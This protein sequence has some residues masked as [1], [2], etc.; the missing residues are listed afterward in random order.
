MFK[1][2]GNRWPLL[3]FLVLSTLAVANSALDSFYHQLFLEYT[4]L[5]PAELDYLGD[6]TVFGVGE[7]RDSLRPWVPEQVAAFRQMLAEKLA[8]MD[9]APVPQDPGEKAVFQGI[10]WFLQT[11]ISWVDFAPYQ[12]IFAPITGDPFALR[13]LFLT[14]HLL[15]TPQDL[16]W[17]LQRLEQVPAKVEGWI[18]RFNASRE[19]GI[20][21]AKDPNRS[22]RYLL[23]E[24]RLK[25][26]GNPV[27][28]RGMQA[29][30]QMEGLTEEQ[31]SAYL[32]RLE[33]A[34]NNYLAPSFNRIDAV[35]L[36]DFPTI[37]KNAG[38]WAQPGGAEFYRF[39]L[40]FHTTQLLD[41]EQIHELGKREVQYLAERIDELNRELRGKSPV[42][43]DERIEDHLPEAFEADFLPQYMPEVKPYSANMYI[44]PR[45]DGKTKG[46]FYATGGVAKHDSLYFH[47][48]VPGHHLERTS[49]LRREIPLICQLTFFTGFIEGWALYAEQLAYE[50]LTDNKEFHELDLL[51]NQYL[52]ALRLV[53]DTGVNY[54]GWTPEEAYRYLTRAGISG[55]LAQSEVSRYLTWPGQAT[56]YYTGYL[57]LLELREKTREAMGEDF[58]LKAFHRLVLE[59]GQ[60]PLPILEE[61]I[62]AFLESYSE[63]E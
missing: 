25:G 28:R 48:V 41:P 23:S 51:Q 5:V 52:R 61:K 30:G 10:Q 34:V 20:E 2:K 37:Q 31:R 46:I 8:W 33:E 53:A 50:L 45:M 12:A 24:M 44:T 39:A 40:R 3:L 57:K 62:H 54:Y 55:G 4:T 56:A 32:Q 11:E 14:R 17:F 29:I 26:V 18:D 43:S 15:Q 22:T 42:A 49:Q 6:L 35:L 9:S 19:M 1:R 7:Y 38:A 36:D 47:E 13:E 59:D 58:S 63:P 60:L 27:Y 21:M 16:D